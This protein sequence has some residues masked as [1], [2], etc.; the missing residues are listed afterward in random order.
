MAALI[1]YPARQTPSLFDMSETSQ[2]S[3]L[4][5]ESM[6]MDP[7]AC[8][9]ASQPPS[10]PLSTE[11]LQTAISERDTERQSRRINGNTITRVPKKTG[12]PLDEVCAKLVI[13]RVEPKSNGGAGTATYYYCIGCD[14]KRANN[15]RGRALP[16]AQ[17][18]KVCHIICILIQLLTDCS[19]LSVATGLR[20]IK[21]PLML[22]WGFRLRAL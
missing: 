1:P 4:P 11:I 18:C 13:E 15:S 12:A 5:P 10:T 17:K 22:S 20:S 21:L 3:S 2:T 14:E 19:S 7:P 16:H 6:D 9:N 8:S